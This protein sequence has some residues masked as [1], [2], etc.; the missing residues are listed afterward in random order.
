MPDV[1]YNHLG[2]E[3]NYLGVFSDHYFTTRYENDWGESLNFDG[4]NS[5]PVREFFVTNGRYWIE[6]FHFDGFRFDATQ[7]IVD[8]SKEYIVGEIGRAARAA[9]GDRSLIL[10]AENEPQETKLV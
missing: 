6:E 1:V 8:S 3:G 2:P 9:A 5:G 7:S 4:S 10:V